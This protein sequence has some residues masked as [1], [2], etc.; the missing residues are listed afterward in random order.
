MSPW[1][2]SEAVENLG[3]IQLRSS[4]VLKWHASRLL[5][6][7][8]ILDKIIDKDTLFSVVVFPYIC[9]SMQNSELSSKRQNMT[10]LVL[11]QKWQYPTDEINL[12]ERLRRGKFS[13]QH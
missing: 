9:N 7:E 13:L 1:Y 4:S 11:S 8:N 6:E 12:I 3:Y 10:S 5:E 2:I